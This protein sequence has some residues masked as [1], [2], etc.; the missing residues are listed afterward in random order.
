MGLGLCFIM[1]ILVTSLQ[2]STSLGGVQ[3]K[4][5][6]THHMKNHVSKFP[7]DVHCDPSL[8]LCDLS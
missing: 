4:R 7:L 3:G 5:K 8:V 2:K 6:S 1:T